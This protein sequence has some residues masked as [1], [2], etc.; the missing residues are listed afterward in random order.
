[1]NRA[2]SIIVN[3][4]NYARFLSHAIDSAL[5]QTYP[6]VEVVVVDD[7]STDESPDII[8]SY[9]EKIRAVLKKNG[10]QGSALNAG[11]ACSTGDIVLF[12]DA[13]DYLSPAAAET[14]ATHWKDET[15]IVHHRPFLINA[16]GEITG[17]ALFYSNVIDAGDEVVPRLLRHGYYNCPPTV[18]LAYSRRLLNKIMPVPEAE[19]PLCA[20]AYL[21][22]SSPFFGRVEAMEESVAYYRLHGTNSFGLPLGR[23]LLTRDKLE[24]HTRYMR[25]RLELIKQR[26]AEFG[27]PAPSFTMKSSSL[28][29]L[30]LYRSA[31]GGYEIG[32]GAALF[33]SLLG[34]LWTEA[35]LT[36]R[37]RAQKTIA[38]LIL[39]VG[40]RALL[41]FIYPKIFAGP[42][43]SSHPYV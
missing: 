26:A 8:R 38:G 42:A 5:A 17:Y 12:L 21:V 10:G 31:P 40:P 18:G 33:R 22:V 9:G 2:V 27:K 11:F 16:A 15:D 35:G 41:R 7:G 24:K 13:D 14:L 32:K 23:R 4:Y 3:S 34:E 36:W 1:M 29:D 20:D 19:W 30:L 28:T 25:Q 6:K 39:T 43:S 37:H